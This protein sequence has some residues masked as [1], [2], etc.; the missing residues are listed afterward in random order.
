MQNGEIQY[1]S[2]HECPTAGRLRDTME[3]YLYS[4][5]LRLLRFLLFVIVFFFI[6]RFSVK[7][8]QKIISIRDSSLQFNAAAGDE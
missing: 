4:K 3:V 6:S 5:I 8:I 2:I 7:E 1:I